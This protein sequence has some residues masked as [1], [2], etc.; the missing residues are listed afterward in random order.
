MNFF[1]FQSP[2]ELF[3]FRNDSK[4]FTLM[5]LTFA[6]YSESDYR[7]EYPWIMVSG[8]IY[9]AN[10]TISIWIFVYAL[11]NFQGNVDKY[12]RQV[13]NVKWQ[14]IEKNFFE[15]LWRSENWIWYFWCFLNVRRFLFF[16]YNYNC[17][18]RQFKRNSHQKLYRHFCDSWNT[19]Y[20]SYRKKYTFNP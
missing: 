15:T 3:N 9:L 4:T 5:L 6:L 13:F 12:F 1:Q 7:F 17:F 14:R 10:F 11:I 19:M 16:L 18:Y 20:P 8:V 2:Q